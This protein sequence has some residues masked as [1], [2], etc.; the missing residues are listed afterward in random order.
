MGIVCGILATGLLLWGTSV[1]AN[2]LPSDLQTFVRGVYFPFER[3][4]WVARQAGMDTWQFVDRLLR[5]LRQRYSMD[6]IWLINSSTADTRKVCE[7]AQQHGIAVFATPEWIYHWRRLR[8]REWAERTAKHT[9]EALGDLKAL[10]AYVLIDE[11]RTWEMTHMEQVRAALAQHDPSRPAIMVNMTRDIEAAAHYTRIP[12]LCSDIYPYFAARSPNGPNTP[13]SS[14][15]YFISCTERLARLGAETGKAVWVMPQIFAEIWGKWH[16]DSKG[17]VVIE[18]GAYW[19]WRMPTVEETRWQIWQSLMVGAKGVIFFV[20]FPEPNDRAPNAPEGDRTDI[21]ADWPRVTSSVPTG[22]GSGMLYNNGSPTPQMLAVAETFAALAPHRALLWRCE[23]AFAFASARAPLRASTL[24]DPED[25]S[26]I[27]VV[28]NDDTQTEQQGFVRLVAPASQVR[29]LLTGKTLTTRERAATGERELILTLPAGGGALLHI[30]SADAA[31]VTTIY[32][33]R[34]TVQSTPAQLQEVHRVW[35]P[36]LWG[37][38][39]RAAWQPQKQ[40]GWLQYEM[41]QVAPGWREGAERLYLHYDGEGVELW[42]SS[43]G[44][45]FSP[46]ARDGVRPPIALSDNVTHLRFVLTKPEAVL[47]EWYL[48]RVARANSAP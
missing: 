12:V 36:D 38:G 18:P 37:M 48:I 43:D 13:E 35:Q 24:R 41:Q 27:V 11:A 34:A 40:T 45:T 1:R 25:G 31:R 15:A 23:P 21:P 33:E 42:V 4:S 5:D 22:A 39:Y 20:L 8:G 14:R 3:V 44:N 19:H 16:Y 2:S 29:D 7:L 30:S 6:A 28:V 47:R 17:N 32:Q 9:V 46:L 10:R 26:L